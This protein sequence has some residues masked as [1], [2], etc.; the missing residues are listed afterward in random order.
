MVTLITKQ[1]QKQS[2]EDRC[3]PLHLHLPAPDHPCAGV[4]LA[5]CGLTP[6]S[7]SWKAGNA[8]PSGKLHEGPRLSSTALSECS[9]GHALQEVHMPSVPAADLS[10]SHETASTPPA[11]PPK[12]HCRSL[13]VPEDLS[14]C[15][16]TWRPSGSKIWTPV[17]RRCNSGGGSGGM[18]PF[19]TQRPASLRLQKVTS[20]S[21]HSIKTCS[22]TFF[23]LALSPDSPV[24]WTFSPQRVWGLLLLC[25]PVPERLGCQWLRLSA[26]F[27]ACAQRRFSLSPVHMHEGPVFFAPSA[28]STP[29]S[30][31][32]PCRRAA[33]LLPRSH[34]QPCD[35][36]HRKVGVKRRH[37]H[38]A[39]WSR[40]V[41]DFFKMTQTRKCPEGEVQSAPRKLLLPFEE[42]PAGLSFGTLGESEAEAD[43]P[44]FQRDCTDLD[45][46]LIEEN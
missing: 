17:K 7:A 18:C 24:P 8:P 38:G 34:S 35:L 14:R 1:L 41:L 25:P 2:L 33:G 12:R 9:P 6:E 4:C 5:A 16:S 20:T 27:S 40:P 10:T 13:S 37:D 43:W 23:S 30:T 15:R 19:A 39:R 42:P 29:S 45:L 11:P 21:L 22:P 46:N 32:E 26:S 44:I 31:P 3:S 36:D 28:S